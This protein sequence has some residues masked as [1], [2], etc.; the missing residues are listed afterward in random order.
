MYRPRVTFYRNPTCIL[1]VYKPVSK[2]K[3]VIYDKAPYPA[4]KIVPGDTLVLDV[5]Y[6]PHTDDQP[7]TVT[8]VG[9]LTGLWGEVEPSVEVKA[10]NGELFGV[11]AWLFSG[12]PPTDN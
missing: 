5:G 3:P 7:C 10:P 12:L 4:D 1:I 6:G 9:R 2:P 11:G 8:K